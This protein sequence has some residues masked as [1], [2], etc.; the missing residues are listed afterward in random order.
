MSQVLDNYIAYRVLTMLVKPFMETDAYKLGIIDK[1]GKNLIKPSSFTT[2]EQKEAYT[3]L[4]RL[5]FNMKKIINK[6]PGG[7]SKLKSLTAAYFLVKEYYE[8]NDRSTSL[9]EHRFHKLMEMGVYFAEETI[10]IEKYMK[11]LEEDGEGAIG[12]TPANSTTGVAGLSTATGGPVV[13]KKDIN[14]YKKGNAT[15][16]VTGLARRATPV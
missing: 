3:F 11:E 1:T 13:K 4:H 7:E 14:K 2:S 8:K 5:V 6:L 12:G 9:M 15:G 10:F 16:P